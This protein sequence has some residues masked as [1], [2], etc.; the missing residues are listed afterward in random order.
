MRINDKSLKLLRQH[1][2]VDS[3]ISEDQRQKDLAS[4]ARVK[5]GLNS[6]EF[7]AVDRLSMIKQAAEKKQRGKNVT[8]RAKLKAKSRRVRRNATEDTRS[9]RSLDAFDERF[10]Y[11]SD[12]EVRKFADGAGI[13]DAYAE[14]V[15]FDEEW[16]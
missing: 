15:R 12:E 11:S 4:I 9:V 10:M 13:A 2:M 8:F 6:G 3:E 1:V 7:V 16:N 5:E 14:T